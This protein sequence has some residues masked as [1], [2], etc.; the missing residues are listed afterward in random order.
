VALTSFTN[1]GNPHREKAAQ[2]REAVQEL[3][4][5]HDGGRGI[6]FEFDGDMSPDVALDYTLMKSLYP[7]CRLTG[8]A[9]VLVMPGLHSANIA[10]KLVQMMAG[11]TVLGPILVGLTSPAQIVQIGAS[12]SDIVNMAAL[13]AFQAIAK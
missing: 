1:F 5:M 10:S 6:D 4:R 7:F 2:V 11:G 9:N 3:E 12:V 8:P 13:G